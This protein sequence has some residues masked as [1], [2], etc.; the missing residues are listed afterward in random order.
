MT[1]GDIFAA[2][3]KDRQVR[4][5]VNR[6]YSGWTFLYKNCE[7]LKSKINDRELDANNIHILY[8]GDYD[9]SGLNMDDLMKEV[10]SEFNLENL[11]HFERQAI[12]ADQITG[13]RLPE[14]VMT[15]KEWERL[16]NDPR[17]KIFKE[18]HGRLFAIELDGLPAIRP[19]EI[20][21]LVQ[22][23]LDS[24]FDNKV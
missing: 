21:N 17:S 4:V 5:V 6:G 10:L 12:T 20:T 22:D 9:P 24:Y 13:F 7:R 14:K 19:N 23:K 18:Y 11:V 15:P 1:L 3:V 8:Y 2:Y 16:E